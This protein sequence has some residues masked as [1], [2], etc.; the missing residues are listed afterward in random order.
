MKLKGKAF[1][2]SLKYWFDQWPELQE[3]KTLK[4]K[5]AGLLS[6]H[7]LCS[8]SR[9][10]YHMSS[11]WLILK[12]LKI[13]RYTFQKSS[14]KHVTFSFPTKNDISLKWEE[15]QTIEK[16]FKLS[17]VKRWV[18]NKTIRGM[19]FL[20]KLFCYFIFYIY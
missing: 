8:I 5:L 11:S 18:F 4:V 12:L 1:I 2:Y 14:P 3:T 6:S 9:Y 17:Y 16:G 13:R 20:N 10:I 7:S 19:I 15:L